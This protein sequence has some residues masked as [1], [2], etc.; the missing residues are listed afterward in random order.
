MSFV[1]FVN[2]IL[3]TQE[4]EY[5]ITLDLPVFSL[6]TK[7]MLKQILVCNPFQLGL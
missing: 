6:F 2:H 3:V 5:L 4:W 7:T 1:L